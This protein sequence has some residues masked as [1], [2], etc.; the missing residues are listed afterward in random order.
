M[1][2]KVLDD[3][4]FFLSD[5][6][7]IIK[8]HSILTSRDFGVF[9]SSHGFE[10]FFE[11]E[12]ISC[13]LNWNWALISWQWSTIA[14][15]KLLQSSDTVMWLRLGKYFH[16]TFITSSDTVIWLGKYFHKTYITSQLSKSIASLIVVPKA[17]Q[18]SSYWKW[19]SFKLNT[20]I[21]QII[22]HE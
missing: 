8:T 19:I 20:Q 22:N 10:T 12:I 18:I 2:K 21:Q 11:T 16:K 4:H 17:F 6:N 1:N 15:A 7:H 9:R 13:N 14:M 5:P 3:T